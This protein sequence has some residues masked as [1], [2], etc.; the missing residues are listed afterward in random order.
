MVTKNL[1]AI[2]E[3]NFNEKQIFNSTVSWT[4]RIR[5]PEILKQ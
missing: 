5:V 4:L 2:T 3:I 1:Q